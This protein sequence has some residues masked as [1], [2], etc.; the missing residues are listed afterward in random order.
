[1]TQTTTPCPFL[2]LA[3]VLPTTPSHLMVLLTHFPANPCSKSWEILFHSSFL[4]FL[5]HFHPRNKHLFSQTFSLKFEIQGWLSSFLTLLVSIIHPLY[6]YYTSLF[7]K[8]M[9][10]YTNI[11]TFLLDLRIFKWFFKCSWVEHFSSSTL[12][13]WNHSRWVHTPIFS[14]FLKFLGGE[15]KLK[16]QEHNYTFLTAFIRNVQLHS[17]TALDDLNIFFS[18]LFYV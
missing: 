17:R 4:S 10:P 7:L 1:M 14:C 9:I 11:I 18:K 2:W 8:S 5:S 15:Y 12:I 16:H 6:D 3:I 13:Y